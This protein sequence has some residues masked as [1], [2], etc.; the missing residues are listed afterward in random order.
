M[1]MV[2]IDNYTLDV[3]K[4]LE[5]AAESTIPYTR[6]KQPNKFRKKSTPGWKEQVKPH[7]DKAIFW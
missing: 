3:I 5:V 6:P 4:W 2:N 7:K 1:H